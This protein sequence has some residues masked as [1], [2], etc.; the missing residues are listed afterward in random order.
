VNFALPE[1]HTYLA[2]VQGPATLIG[3]SRMKPVGAGP[4]WKWEALLGTSAAPDLATGQSR[5]I[6]PYCRERGSVYAAR[7]K[8]KQGLSGG[9]IVAAIVTLGFTLL[10]TGLSR[11]V[12]T[13]ELTCGSC[14]MSWDA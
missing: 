13:T 10:L 6:C 5:I 7:G 14:G 2:A 12:E 11:K 8:R 1:T 9:K 3:M 4:F